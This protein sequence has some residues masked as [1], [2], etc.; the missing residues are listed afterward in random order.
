MGSSW[1]NQSQCLIKGEEGTLGRE[2]RCFRATACLNSEAQ[3]LP[4]ND[5]MSLSNSPLTLPCYNSRG[6]YQIIHKAKSPDAENGNR[7]KGPVTSYRCLPGYGFDH[8]LR[9]S[10]T[11]LSTA[12]NNQTHPSSLVIHPS[13]S[14]P[15]A[16]LNPKTCDSTCF[17]TP[18]SARRQATANTDD[19]TLFRSVGRRSSGPTGARRAE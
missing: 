4:L 13:I 11:T 7:R 17:P 19:S 15:L 9:N 14:S 3:S 12:S 6:T 16:F 8:G 2:L 18:P 10:S 1:T 5:A